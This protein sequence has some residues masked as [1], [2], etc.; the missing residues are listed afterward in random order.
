MNSTEE[1]RKVPQE[2]L[3]VVLWWLRGVR[4]DT[5]DVRTPQLRQ[6]IADG[7]QLFVGLY[8]L[9]VVVATVAN[10]ALVITV[11]RHRLYLPR[12]YVPLPLEP[13]T[14]QHG[15]RLPRRPSYHGRHAPSQLALRRLLMSPDTNNTGAHLILSLFV[16]VVLCV[17]YILNW[18]FNHLSLVTAFR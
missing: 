14:L 1:I 17:L 13:H 8:S 18:I 4:N 3:G 16:I 2:W 12:P 9:V 15:A 6:S 11:R 10:V 5:D 7:Y